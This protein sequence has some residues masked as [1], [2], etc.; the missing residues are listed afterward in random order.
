MTVP[1]PSPAPIPVGVLVV[2][3]EPQPEEGLAVVLRVGGQ[4]V[5]SARAGSKALAVLAEDPP[6]ALEC[7][8]SRI[9]HQ[10]GERAIGC[11][12][13]SPAEALR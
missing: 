13:S 11:W 5:E 10:I 7:D 8:P 12:P 1:V 9:E 4:V 2:D 3:G 6:E